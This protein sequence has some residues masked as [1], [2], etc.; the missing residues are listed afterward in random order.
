[1]FFFNNVIIQYGYNTAETMTL[2]HSYSNTNYSIQGTTWQGGNYNQVRILEKTISTIKWWA[3]DG[4][5][6]EWFTIG[7]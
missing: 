3:Y 6:I 4:K 5:K 2:P 7:I 1:M